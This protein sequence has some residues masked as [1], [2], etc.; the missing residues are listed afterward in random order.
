MQ[1][2]HTTGAADAP[3]ALVQAPVPQPQPSESLVRVRAVSLNAGELRRARK[4]AGGEPIGWDFSGSIERAAAD[5]SGPAEGTRVVGFVVNGAWAEY[6]AAPARQLGVLPDAVTFNDAATLP[7]AGL[8]AL[9]TLR[10]GGDLR[11]KSVLIVPGTGGVGLFALQL[12][13]R[14][15]AR[16]SAVIRS[17]KNEALVRG[18]GAESVYVG[19]G[20]AAAG[21]AT[22]DVIVESLGGDSLGAAL[23]MLAPDGAV[24]SFGQT[25]GATTTF[26]A[27]V[28]YATGGATLHGFIIFH[29]AE[30]APVADDL[31]LLATLVGGG[32]VKTNIDA[33]VPFVQFTEA[34]ST[35][36]DRALSGKVVVT[37][38]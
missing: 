30:K 6:V 5:G 14:G 19:A 20:A 22:F 11:G 31:E 15:G 24:V 4:R 1:A 2:V 9:R 38:P 25:A 36:T 29:D 8:T 21:A 37:V 33:I 27:D 16:V 23:A 28:F 26:A 34:I 3:V 32:E 18:L 12:A 13:K 17:A 7:I 35:R 10:R